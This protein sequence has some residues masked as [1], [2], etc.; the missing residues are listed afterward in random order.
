MFCALYLRPRYQV[1]VYRTIG[2][3]VWILLQVVNWKLDD[4]VN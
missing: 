1:R 2:P 4:T 3:L